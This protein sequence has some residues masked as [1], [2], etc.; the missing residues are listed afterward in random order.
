MPYGIPIGMLSGQE[1]P[2]LDL[3]VLLSKCEAWWDCDE[4]GA[5]TRYDQHVNSRD[6]SVL[7]GITDVAGVG[8]G[9]AMQF[10]AGGDYC[11]TAAGFPTGT[12]A[13]AF[14]CFVHF[15]ALSGNDFIV[16][17]AN[18]GVSGASVQGDWTLGRWGGGTLIWHFSS[19]GSFND[20]DGTNVTTSGDPVSISAGNTYWA[21][22]DFIPGSPNTIRVSINNGALYSNTFSHT[23]YTNGN[24]LRFGHMTS[25]Y[26]HNLQGW[27]T[28][29]NYWNAPLSDLERA[30]LYNSMT[31][32][33]YAELIA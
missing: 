31:G 27:L 18:S 13:F 4:V 21:Y 23:Y 19:D 14:S 12:A 15:D 1:A 28:R 26:P 24:T 25:S 5:G 8:G 17:R 22:C 10:N 33:T 30:W 16:W 2:G 7:S 6:I 9:R 3:D 32:R 20:W 11:R 29:I